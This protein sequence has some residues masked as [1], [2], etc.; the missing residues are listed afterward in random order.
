MLKSLAV[1]P[2]VCSALVRYSLR[3]CIVAAHS[4]ARLY[5]SNSQNGG[6]NF[7]NR[8]NLPA[9]T[10]IKFV[11]Q[12]EAWIV[13]RMGKFRKVLQPGL[14]ILM[15]FL[16]KIQYVQSLKEVALE[17]PSQ[18]TITSDNVTLD[19]DG[20]LYY[21]VVDPYKASYG[22]EDA[23]YAIV[24]LAQTTMR[25]E[26]GQMSLDL[27]LRER[28]TLNSHIT[29]AINEAAQDW[30]IR[31]LRYEIRDIRPPV[32]VVSS[33]NQVVEKDR[34]KRAVILES[35]GRSQSEI[36]ISQAHKTTEVLKSEGEMRK[37]INWA[38][39]ASEAVNLQAVAD[40][41][42]I[43]TIAKAISDTPGGKDA[44]SLHIAEKYIES[45]GNLAKETNTLILPANLD[46]FS[47]FIAAGMG[48]YQNLDNKQLAKTVLSSGKKPIITAT[49]TRHI[50]K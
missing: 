26:I 37:R 8:S 4:S 15:P 25:S 38:K 22:V 21:R 47:Q 32:N 39:G 35:E 30:G 12:Q 18:S 24:Q 11:P 20:V 49:A 1:K 41:Q 36:N 43:T 42:A 17:V 7:F 27:C 28:T 46:N 13:E 45:F 34:Q 44:V 2:S 5:S 33:M 9:N 3:P 48:I 14:S 10:I 19:M 40:A 50:S 16:D 29:V 31:V 23:Q 6:L